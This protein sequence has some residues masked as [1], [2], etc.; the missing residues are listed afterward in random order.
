MKTRQFKFRIWDIE[1]KTL[2]YDPIAYALLL[3]GS[4]C[5]N[6]YYQERDVNKYIVQQFT[7]MYDI[8]K[9]EIYEGDIIE[10]TKSNWKSQYL[11]IW[12]NGSFRAATSRKTANQSRFIICPPRLFQMGA[13]VVGNCFTNPNFPAKYC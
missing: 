3:D 9:T 11:I 12:K 5:D 1:A 8:N 2:S 7:E 10:D 4:V 13:K 6:Y